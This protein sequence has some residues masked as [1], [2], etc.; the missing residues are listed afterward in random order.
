MASHV[1]IHFRSLTGSSGGTSDGSESLTTVRSAWLQRSDLLGQRLQWSD[2]V[3]QE[4]P[5]PGTRTSGATL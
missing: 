1:R 5:V 4:V 3:G 2:L